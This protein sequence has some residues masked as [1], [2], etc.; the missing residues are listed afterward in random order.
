M[1]I[2][3]IPLVLLILTAIGLMAIIWCQMCKEYSPLISIAIIGL[4]IAENLFLILNRELIIEIL[5]HCI[6]PVKRLAIKARI[7]RLPQ[8]KRHMTDERVAWY[9]HAK[10]HFLIAHGGGGALQRYANSCEAIEK[11]MRD[12]FHVIEVDVSM[13]ADNIPVLSHDFNPDEE[14]YWKHW[15]SSAEFLSTLLDG[16]YHPLS[17]EE[18]RMQ[19]YPCQDFVLCSIECQI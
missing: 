7:N 1:R 13:T 5:E 15:P 12:G 11:S 14:L 3:R 8:N 16:R 18:K 6:T 2:R 19:E 9:T 17:L 10:G 4:L